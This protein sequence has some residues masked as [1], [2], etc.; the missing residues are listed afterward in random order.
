[1][2]RRRGRPLNLVV[3]RRS[4]LN[5]TLSDDIEFIVTVILVISTAVF[6]MFKLIRLG[7]RGKSLGASFF[8]AWLGLMVAAHVPIAQIVVAPA[9]SLLELP[10]F[11]ASQASHISYTFGYAMCTSALSYAVLALYCAI[12]A[13]FFALI[14]RKLDHAKSS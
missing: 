11:K 10:I 7:I 5:V 9:M 6:L 4:S 1:V 2:L 8:L 14:S 3:R 12:L 13:F